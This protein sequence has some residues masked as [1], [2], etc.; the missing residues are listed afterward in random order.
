MCCFSRGLTYAIK[1]TRSAVAGMV[2]CQ[3]NKLHLGVRG[4]D[5]FIYIIYTWK[6]LPSVTLLTNITRISLVFS[7]VPFLTLLIHKGRGITCPDPLGN[8]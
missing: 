3:D 1:W 5:T 7:T 2:I 4:N 6:V 8:V